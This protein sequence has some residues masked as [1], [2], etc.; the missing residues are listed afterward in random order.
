MVTDKF[1]K[2]PEGFEG[3]RRYDSGVSDSYS[4]EWR[5]YARPIGADWWTDCGLVGHG[6]L[7]VEELDSLAEAAITQH[8]TLGVV[9]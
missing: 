4:G 6:Q 9:R 1:V 8:V 3:K 7:G 5:A 2:A